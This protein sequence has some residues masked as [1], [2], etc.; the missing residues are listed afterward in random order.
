[1]SVSEVNEIVFKFING[2]SNSYTFVNPVVV[3]ILKYGLYFL[4]AYLVLSFIFYRQRE[5]HRTMILAALITFGISE[6]IGLFVSKFFEHAPPF[7]EIENVNLLIEQASGSNL[8]SMPCHLTMFFFS[9]CCA[10]QFC[11]KGWNGGIVTFLAFVVAISQIWAGLKYPSD[12]LASIVIPF[13]VSIIISAI[14]I[15]TDLLIRPIKYL[16]QFEDRLLGRKK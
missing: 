2:L 4:L 1:M 14:A 10:M 3:F 5:K 15:N 13:V 11:S 6:L 7:V 16:N 8:S 12:V 9:V